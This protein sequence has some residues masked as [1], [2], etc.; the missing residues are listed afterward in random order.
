MPQASLLDPLLF[1][2]HVLGFWE[3]LGNCHVHQYAP[4]AQICST[5]DKDKVQDAET[6]INADLW[7]ILNISVAH[8]LTLNSSRYVMLWP[9]RKN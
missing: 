6:H 7:S 9:I 8:G 1:L 3:Y 2:V 4:D 5:F